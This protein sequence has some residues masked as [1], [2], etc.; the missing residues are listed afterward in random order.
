MRYNQ[1]NTPFIQKEQIPARFSR[2]DVLRD[3]AAKSRRYADTNRATILSNTAR[4]KSYITFKT[5]SG[6]VK[7]VEALLWGMD[8]DFVLLRSGMFLP[9]RSILEINHS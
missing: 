2:Q 9:L 3:A 1:E 8:K 5:R 7:R 4:N 6:D